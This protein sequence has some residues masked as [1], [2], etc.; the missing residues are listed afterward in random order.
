MCAMIPMLRVFCSG[1]AWAI[2]GLPL[3]VAEGLVGVP[4]PVGVLAALAA[5]ADPVRG[6]HELGGQ[7]L[8]H[9]AAVPLARGVDEPAHAEADAAIRSHLDG[10]LVGGSTDALG[11]DLDQRHG[12]PQGELH[13]LDSG[14]PRLLLA[15]GDRVLEDAGGEL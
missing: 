7:L 15:A 9:A 3:E 10:D 14:S 11:L 4:H 12:V 6:V 13:H 2:I 5:V 1:Y 8:A